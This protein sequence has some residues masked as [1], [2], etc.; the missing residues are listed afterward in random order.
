[1]HK[2]VGINKKFEIAII[3]MFQEQKEFICKEV[4]EGMM[5]MPLQIKNIN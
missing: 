2:R 1:M 3:N 4:N 5:T